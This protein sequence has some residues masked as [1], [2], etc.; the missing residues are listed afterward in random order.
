MRVTGLLD[1]SLSYLVIQTEVEDGIHHTRHR[2][3][4]TWAYWYEEWILYRTEL[5]V[6]QCLSMSHSS[7]H[8][9]LKK[10][11]DFF[12]TH[13]IIF[14]TSVC[15]NGE[16]WRNRYT[17]QVHF[18]KVRAFTTKYFSH[19]GIAFCFSVSE[20]INSFFVHNCYRYMFYF[21][22]RC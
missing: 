17:N 8:F 20:C 19:L 18:G 7:H 16:T 15:C 22:L 5:A 11:F 21:V 9:V 1:Q 10:F 4:C 13:F 6:H 3:A 12:L 14:I 2:C